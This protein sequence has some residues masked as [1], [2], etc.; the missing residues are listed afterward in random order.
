M[1]SQMVGAV[2]NAGNIDQQLLLLASFGLD[3]AV[4]PTNDGLQL[5]LTRGSGPG[6]QQ[7]DLTPDVGSQGADWVGNPMSYILIGGSA[8]GYGDGTETFVYNN[9][10][11]ANASLSVTMHNNVPPTP[12]VKAGA[13]AD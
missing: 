3:L 12:P 4:P 11:P 8:Y 5:L 9:G 2:L 10:D 7:W 1:Y 6:L 13:A